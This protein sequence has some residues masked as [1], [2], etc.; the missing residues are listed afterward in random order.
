MT[1]ARRQER[2][3]REGTC[4]ESLGDRPVT[5]RYP[6]PHLLSPFSA[7]FGTLNTSHTPSKAHTQPSPTP[8]Q[9]LQSFTATLAMTALVGARECSNGFLT[10]LR[11]RDGRGAGRWA[12]QLGAGAAGPPARGTL[13]R[14][15]A[16]VTS[17]YP[18]PATTRRLRHGLRHGPAALPGQRARPAGGLAAPWLFMR[19]RHRRP[20]PGGGSWHVSARSAL[21]DSR[22]VTDLPSYSSCALSPG[23]LHGQLLSAVHR[24]AAEGSGARRGARRRR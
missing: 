11:P 20:P 22:S 17:L 1:Y 19:A 15:L 4:C 12:L 9:R 10:R 5:A 13:R 2:A 24:A 23:S 8:P 6:G 3:R 7:S 21:L 18:L 14:W 16:D